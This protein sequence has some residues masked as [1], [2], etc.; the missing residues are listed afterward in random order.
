MIAVRKS[1]D[2]GH[3]D[4]GWLDTFHSFSFSDYYDPNF[5][6][7]RALRVINEDRVAPGS[8]FP[9]HFHRDME[10]IT[11]PLAGALQHRDGLGNGSVIRP[12]EVQRM[13]AG[14]GITHSEANPSKTEP[15]H[16]LQIWI[17]PNRKG[18]A[19]GYQQKVFPEAER[20][21]QLRLVASPE[22]R[23]G[24]LQIHQDALV[25]ASLLHPGGKLIHRLAPGRHAW[26]QLAR[27]KLRLNGIEL[28][29]GDGAATS[30]ESALELEAAA[31]AE[32]LLFD[33]A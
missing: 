7:F 5:L 30:E 33:L 25:Y 18:L 14:T 12:G 2:R 16:L 8:G 32:F 10:I 17:L 9:T 13:T 11:Y 28:E 1:N 26:V 27:G 20:R 29:S 19:P 31:P 21:G 15:V 24:S 4:Y 22:A 23:S 6:G 3:F